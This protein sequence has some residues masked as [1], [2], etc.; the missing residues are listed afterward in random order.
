MCR[1]TLSDP[2]FSTGS[3]IFARSNIYCRANGHCLIE[4]MR[5]QE[6]GSG[7]QI[8]MP[9][10]DQ[11]RIFTLRQALK[12]AS[13]NIWLMQKPQQSAQSCS[14]IACHLL[15]APTDVKGSLEHILLR[16]PV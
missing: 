14:S 6:H 3:S 13:R 15:A 5:S 11:N 8:L 9:A 7:L 2:D 4:R 1:S 16:L 10:E 12:A